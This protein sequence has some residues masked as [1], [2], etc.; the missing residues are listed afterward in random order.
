MP[1]R[2]WKSS[3][4]TSPWPM[5]HE[6]GTGRGGVRKTVPWGCLDRAGSGSDTVSPYPIPVGEGDQHGVTFVLFAFSS[7][8]GAEPPPPASTVPA[9]KLKEQVV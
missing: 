4:E 8:L 1:A 9:N 5:A 3:S 2:P 7:S 6:G